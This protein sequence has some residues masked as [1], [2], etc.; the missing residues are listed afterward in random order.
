MESGANEPLKVVMECATACHLH[1]G[2]IEIQI[3][4]CTVSIIIREVHDLLVVSVAQ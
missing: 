1:L 3:K 4:V 2:T